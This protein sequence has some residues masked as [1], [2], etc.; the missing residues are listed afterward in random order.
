M[1]AMLGFA[2]YYTNQ[3]IQSWQKA[4]IVVSIDTRPINELTFPSVSICHS[5]SWMWPNIVNMLDYFDQEELVKDVIA[6]HSIYH[7][8]KYYLRRRFKT[9]SDCQ[10]LFEN[11]TLNE[12]GSNDTVGKSHSYFLIHFY[13][14]QEFEFLLNFK[15]GSSSKCGDYEVMN[16]VQEMQLAFSL[17]ALLSN[18]S[19][20]LD[21]DYWCNNIER[22][23]FNTK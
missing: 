4:P 5:L 19:R 16:K 22:N 14:Y 13:I 7:F 8:K 20:K 3:S 9:T 6:R 12:D 18:G 23:T 10:D 11:F 2:I 15:N 21:F 1:I 17:S